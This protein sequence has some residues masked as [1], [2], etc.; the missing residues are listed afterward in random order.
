MSFKP[1]VLN[2]PLPRGSE[3]SKGCEISTFRPLGNVFPN[4]RDWANQQP[5]A[6]AEFATERAILLLGCYRK[7]DAHDPETY[8]MAVVAILTDYPAEVVEH[9]TDPRT[10]IA[11]K[12]KFLPSVAEV[13]EGCEGSLLTVWAGYCKAAREAAEAR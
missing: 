6:E 10:G 4:M 1:V 2:L 13:A 8:T 11:R 5:K 12:C 9:A 3:S 7:D